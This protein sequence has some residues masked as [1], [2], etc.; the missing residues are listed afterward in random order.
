MKCYISFVSDLTHH[1]D[2][3]TL[4][5]CV[6]Q[7]MTDRLIS[8]AKGHYNIFYNQFVLSLL[9]SINVI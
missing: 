1:R 6:G 3:G 5:Y 7:P 9:T 4:L 8:E 2:S